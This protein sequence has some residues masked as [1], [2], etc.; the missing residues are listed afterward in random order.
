MTVSTTDISDLN[1]LQR[2]YTLPTSRVKVQKNFGP[3]HAVLIRHNTTVL[4]C[5]CIGMLRGLYKDSLSYDNLIR[6]QAK[7]IITLPNEEVP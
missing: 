6:F 1:T 5:D 3:N 2:L 7:V 4:R